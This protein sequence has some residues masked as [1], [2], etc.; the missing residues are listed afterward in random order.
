MSL[1]SEAR[2]QRRELKWREHVAAEFEHYFPERLK[3]K[4]EPTYS[5][6]VENAEQAWA[7]LEWALARVKP[8]PGR[9]GYQFRPGF[10]RTVNVRRE[11]TLHRRS[12]DVGFL[13]YVEFP[14]SV[15]DEAKAGHSDAYAEKK[16]RQEIF[17]KGK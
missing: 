7:V 10:A 14:R 1:R 16:V 2:K 3:P 17:G 5:M 8:D 6:P 15:W 9:N 11:T 12:D 13:Y 4:A